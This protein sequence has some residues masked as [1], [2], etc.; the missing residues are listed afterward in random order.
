MPAL[1][2]AGQVLARRLLAWDRARVAGH[3]ARG[4]DVGVYKARQDLAEVCIG[5]DVDSWPD[6][7]RELFAR[8]LE[9]TRSP[10]PAL[11][12]GIGPMRAEPLALTP[13][14][15]LAYVAL[16]R[17]LGVLEQLRE[18]APNHWSDEDSAPP[19]EVA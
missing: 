6:E 15:R 13:A 8:V 10:V 2:S 5:A 9:V 17:E 3:A 4:F 14:D 16:A 19:L 11:E 1:T 12:R 18:T 7:V